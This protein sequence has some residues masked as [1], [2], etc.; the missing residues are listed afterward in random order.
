MPPYIPGVNA[1]E[2]VR[3]LR[4][5][6]FSVSEG[7]NHAVFRH[8]RLGLATFVPRHG[9]DVDPVTMGSILEQIGMTRAEF[10]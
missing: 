2:V 3:I 6:N 5:L 10:D 8:E 1:R 4:R 7:G 9:G